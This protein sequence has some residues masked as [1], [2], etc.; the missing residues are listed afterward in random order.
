MSL[1]PFAIRARGNPCGARTIA[2]DEPLIMGVV[3]V[4]PD[5]FSDGGQLA[6]AAAAIAHG[7]AL[8]HA[9]ADILDVGGEA[10]NWRAQP[11]TAAVELA[12]VVPVLMGL[13][14]TTGALLSIDTTKA[15]VARAAIAAGADLVNDVSGGLFDP[16]IVTVADDAGVGYVLGHLRGR[17]LAEVFAAEAP[18]AWTE[19]RDE[20]GARLAA[21]PASLARRTMVD[22]GIGVGKGADAAT[23]LALLARAG[24]LAAALGRPIVVGPSR[25]RFLA[26]VLGEAS[27]PTE[28]AARQAALDDATI[29]ACLAAVAAGAHVVRVHAVGRVRAALTAFRAVA[30]G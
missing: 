4:T 2:L 11:V 30:G 22:P 10:T 20:L 6:D 14:A 25:K 8:W 19:V 24:D 12:R 1:P 9:G 16:D 23:N 13:A 18:A 29:G 15:E 5:S 21:L 7:Q 27:L 3:N 26:R 28:P 17:T